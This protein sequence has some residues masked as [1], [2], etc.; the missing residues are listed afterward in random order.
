MAGPVQSWIDYPS[1][2]CG[3]EDQDLPYEQ[4]DWLRRR[5]TSR[6]PDKQGSVTEFCRAYEAA[7]GT[8]TGCD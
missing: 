6:V 4:W 7:T 1:V 8:L 2:Q 3:E 5:L